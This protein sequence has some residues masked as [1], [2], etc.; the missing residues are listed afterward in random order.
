MIKKLSSDF[1]T[2]AAFGVGLVWIVPAILNFVMRLFPYIT[3]IF[4]FVL[5]L[6]KHKSISSKVTSYISFNIFKPKNILSYYLNSLKLKNIDYNTMTVL[7]LRQYM[8]DNKIKIPK[9]GTGS[10]GGVKKIDLLNKL[11]N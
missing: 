9:H 7:E 10:S 1:L 5:C 4:F 8:L 11:K 2:G 6:V 3:F